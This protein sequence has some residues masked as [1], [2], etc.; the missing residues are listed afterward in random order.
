MKQSTPPPFRATTFVSPFRLVNT[1]P[2]KNNG[3]QKPMQAMLPQAAVHERHT[4]RPP[5]GSQR[6]RKHPPIS[7]ASASGSP[8]A[9]SSAS[10]HP[11]P[12]P[13]LC[14]A[15]APSRPPAI[16]ALPQ[17][18]LPPEQKRDGRPAPPPPPLHLGEE[19][20]EGGGE[21]DGESLE[22]VERLWTGHA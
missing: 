4:G 12:R 7:F 21:G 9:R 11:P 18:E 6:T 15:G 3:M 10:P 19:P 2:A 14:A 1:P 16:P 5:H 22:A 20:K 13:M 8:R 17:P